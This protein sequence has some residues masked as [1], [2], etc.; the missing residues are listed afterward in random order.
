[1]LDWLKRHDPGR[2]F[3]EA[4]GESLTY[5]E[6]VEAVE[7]RSVDAVE[8]I[9]PRLDATSVI[10]VIASMS[11]VTAVLA[12][13]H[14]DPAPFD[15][16]GAASVVFTSGTTGGPKGV[17]LTGGTW[18][19]ACDA[20]MRH[21][22][23]GPEDIWL[24]AMPL[25]HVAGLSIVLRSAYVGGRVRM[26]DDFEPAG[27]AAHLRSGVTM[28]SMVSTMLSRVLEED[29]GPYD[30]LKAVLLG[31]GP[32]PTGLLENG[33]AAG[34]PLL[35][36]YGLTETAGQVATL[37]PVD[38]PAPKAYPLPGAELRLEPDGRIAVRGPMVSPGYV[39]EPDR[40]PGDW[41][42][43]GDLGSIDDDGALRVLGRADRVIVSG[44]E[45]IDPDRL[46]AEIASVPGVD[47]ALVVGLPS[48][49]WGME[50]V[51][52]YVGDIDESEVERQLR[53]RLPGFMIPRRWRQVT[54][55]PATAMGKPDR[56]EAAKS[57]S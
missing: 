40:A 34:L 53:D 11:R 37:R 20:S 48:E 5:G 2:V 4:P 6:M 15:T 35:P 42:V 26:L 24:L 28:A 38:P 30:R 54:V 32:I 22:G 49:E 50:A 46:E 27:F 10:D 47:R 17:R 1:M 36:T 8:V 21:L 52:L 44:G 16:A 31:G 25:H 7:G 18:E 43:T 19:A 41:L 9:R 12:P 29:P 51:C 23:H 3:L 39:G 55:L 45:N 13:D 56:A 33:V 14:I 57:F